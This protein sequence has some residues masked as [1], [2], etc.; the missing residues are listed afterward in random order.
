MKIDLAIIGA[1][2]AGTT[3]LKNYLGEHPEV[4]THPHVEFS[5]FQRDE[6][7]EKGFENTFSSNFPG[8]KNGKKILIKNAGMYHNRLA[9]QRLKEHNPNCKIVFLLRNPVSRAYSSYRMEKFYGEKK[10]F[11]HIINVIEEN[12]TQDRFFRIF[13]Q[14]G[15]YIDFL[16][17]IYSLF[18]ENQVK[19]IVYENFKKNP[20]GF[21]REI[22]EWL[23]I[24]PFFNPNTKVI[25]NKSGRERSR[26]FGAFLFQMRQKD[27]P[28]KNFAKGILPY[29]WFSLIR[30][31]L[32][33]LNKKEEA[34]QSIG[35]KTEK[36]L[37]SYYEH[38]NK[39]LEKRTELDLS[40]WKSKSD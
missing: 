4:A 40:L 1:Q 26:V 24:D 21:C 33:Q 7:F 10:P 30:N 5:H 29:H 23:K 27:N 14:L 17:Y 8:Y 12:D 32:I 25:H 16:K 20:S 34:G 38:F 22:F 28:I 6:E 15:Q 36:S 37:Y 35:K 2:K 39:E 19:L 9:L 3:S 13:I 11:D 31:K 18:P